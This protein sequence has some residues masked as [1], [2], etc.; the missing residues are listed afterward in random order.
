M[1]DRERGESVA[2]IITCDNI[3]Y[4]INSNTIRSNLTCGN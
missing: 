4:P 1:A 2:R 3:Y